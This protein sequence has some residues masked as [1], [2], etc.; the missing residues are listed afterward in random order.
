MSIKPTNA[1]GAL[2]AL[3]EWLINTERREREEVNGP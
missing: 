3:G 2:G 1:V